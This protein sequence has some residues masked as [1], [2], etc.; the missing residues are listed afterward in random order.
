MRIYRLANPAPI[1]WNLLKTLIAVALFDAVV[2]WGIPMLLV[3]I[4]HSGVGLDLF[5]PPQNA[6]GE[7]ILTASTV[8]VL[9]AAWMLAAKG[10]ELRSRLTRR[11]AW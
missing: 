6:I 8:M 3:R 5:F 1:A 11:G 4:Q 10:G 9:W 2:V 7:V